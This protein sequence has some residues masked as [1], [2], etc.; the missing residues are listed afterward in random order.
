MSPTQSAKR[1]HARTFVS[2]GMEREFTRLVERPTRKN[3]LAARDAV[4]R[5]SPQLVQTADLVEIG[6]LLDAGDSAQA[7]DRLAELAPA[8]S[9][10]PRVHFLAAE[11]AEAL[12]DSE[13]CEL[14]RF[15]FVVCIRGLLA[16]GDGSRQAPYD[17]C[18]AA[19]ASDLLESLGFEPVRQS[20]VPRGART[21]DVVECTTGRQLWFDVTG[22]LPPR[23]MRRTVTRPRKAKQAAK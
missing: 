4:L 23:Q 18:N 9:L 10:S 14:E 20:L 2:R 16:T 7:L 8:A 22:T 21:Y 12:G 3:Y 1:Q 13:N 6:Q 11:A 19:D 15:L 5:V 17:I